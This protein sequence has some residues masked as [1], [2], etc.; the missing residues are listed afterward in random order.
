M[1]MLQK[2]SGSNTVALVQIPGHQGILGNEEADKLYMD[3][4]NRVLL[5]K[6]LAS[7]LMWVKKSSGAI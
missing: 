6:L 2:L 5:I 7:P 3:G 4:T 1:Q